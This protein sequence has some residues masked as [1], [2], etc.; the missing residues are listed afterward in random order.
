M[1]SGMCG[2]EDYAPSGLGTS[3]MRIPQQGYT[4]PLKAYAPSGLCHPHF[5]PEGALSVTD[6]CSPS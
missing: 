1:M 3:L 2:T 4:L 5:S 6:G